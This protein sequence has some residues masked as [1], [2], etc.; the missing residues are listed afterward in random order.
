MATLSQ[1]DIQ[2]LFIGAA[3]TK[4]TTA[5]PTTLNTGEIGIFTPSGARVTEASAATIDKFRIVAKQAD[6]TLVDSGIINKN[7]IKTANRKVYTAA[8][9]MQV[10][11]GYNGTSGSIEEI[12]DNK[13]HVRINL[14]QARVSNHGGLYM[15]HAFYTS[16]VNATQFEIASSLLLNLANEVSKEADIIFLPFMLCN[17]AGAALGAGPE[18]L[19]ATFGSKWVVA[20]GAGHT[21]VAGDVLR[22]G[23]TATTNYVYKVKS[24]SGANIELE[25]PYLG[26]TASLLD[27]EVITAANAAT[28][29][30]GIQIKGF[31]QPYR[32]GHLE[33]DFNANIFDVTL[34]EFGTTTFSVD[35]VATP[36]SGTERQVKSMEFFLQGNEGDDLRTPA[37]YVFDRRSN[38]SGN[39]DLIHITTEELATNSIVAGPIRKAFTLAIPQTAPNY[40]VTGTA[41]D[42]TD[43]LEV[44]AFGSANGNLAVS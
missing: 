32:V 18:T 6:G 7:D 17:D 16:D 29:D 42:I 35:T 10:T 24:V 38:A 21:V 1:R 30:F 5:N 31:A 27:G 4:T 25:S 34:E 9:Q 11:I 28:A 43:V 44:L 14:R 39:Y 19:T 13:Y 23:G 12:N 40:A 36:G 2:L 8:T 20:S 37:P 41:D 3:A 15:K 26:A 22:I 33:Q